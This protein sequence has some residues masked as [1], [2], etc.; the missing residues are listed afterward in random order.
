M[1]RPDFL[2]I[3]RKQNIELSSVKKS[4]KV[5]LYARVAE[6][7]DAIDLGSIVLGRASSSLAPGT[8]F[9]KIK[10]RPQMGPA[11]VQKQW[12]LRLEKANRI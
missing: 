5:F 8:T 1:A 7:V 6:L 2:I 3:S 11:K 4:P 9:K 12:K 10:M